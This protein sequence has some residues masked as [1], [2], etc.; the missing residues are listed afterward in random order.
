MIWA[1]DGSTAPLTLPTGGR[2]A[3]FE[4]TADGTACLYLQRASATNATELFVVPLDASAAPLKLSHP[5]T[6]PSEVL[7][8]VAEDGARIA[9]LA[10]DPEARLWI[11]VRDGSLTPFE[12]S[13]VGTLHGPVRAGSVQFIDGGR[14]AYLADSTV[15]P[16]RD[17]WSVP[18][19]GSGPPVRLNGAPGSSNVESYRLAP[20]LDRIVYRAVTDVMGLWSAPTDGSTAPVRLSNR[21]SGV[22]YEYSLSPDGW[23]AYAQFSN[24]TLHLF[25]VPIDASRPRRQASGSDIRFVVAPFA[26]AGDRLLYTAVELPWFNN[27]ALFGTWTGKAPRSH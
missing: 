13:A 3:R 21:L 10:A 20:G 14:I 22:E 4:P 26:F 7:E 23:A 8:F 11:T 2:I 27:P 15:G 16:Y 5:L 19:D 24:G 9:Y 6:A 25:L 1:A 17:L 12:A 18:L